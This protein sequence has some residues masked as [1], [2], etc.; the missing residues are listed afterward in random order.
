MKDNKWLKISAS[1]KRTFQGE[2]ASRTKMQRDQSSV[3]VTRVRFV[4]QVRRARL[5]SAGMHC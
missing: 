1:S 4:T 3:M 2:L 5:A